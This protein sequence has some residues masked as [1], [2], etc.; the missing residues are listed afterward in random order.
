MRS[1]GIQTYKQWSEISRRDRTRWIA[2][3]LLEKDV[4]GYAS[5]AHGLEKLI[6][7]VTLADWRSADDSAR[8]FMI[9]RTQDKK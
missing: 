2:F 5:H 7:P 8:K 9:K 4:E 3:Y 6:P 1:L